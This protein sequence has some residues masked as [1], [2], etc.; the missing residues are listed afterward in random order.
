MMRPVILSSPENSAELLAIFCDGGWVMLSSSSGG[1]AA[2]AGDAGRPGWRW[3][4]G[5][6]LESVGLEL[7]DA[8]G[9]GGKGCDCTAPGAAPDR[10]AYGGLLGAGYCCGGAGEYGGG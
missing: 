1:A 10:P 2:S 8:P 7:P 6:R 3:L 4:P 9:G 5:G